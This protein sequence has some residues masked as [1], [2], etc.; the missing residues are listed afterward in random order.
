MADKAHRLTDKKL[1]EMEKRLSS[2]YSGSA[3]IIEK[4]AADYFRQ[5]ERMDE[6]KR[7][8]VEKGTLTDDEYKRWRKNKLLYAERF[9]TLQNQIATEMLNVNKTA[10]AYVN[11][12][13]PEVYAI[14]YNAIGETVDGVGGYSFTMVDSN[15]VK[16]LATR[17]SRLLP[18]KYIDQRKDKKW[19]MRN[20]H[21]SVLQSIL[22]GESIPDMAKRL[23]H[24][25]EMNKEQ[26]IRMARTLTT[27]AENK[28]RQDSCE[29]AVSDGIILEK[30]WIRT[31]DARTREEH[32]E[33]GRRY[34]ESRSIAIDKPFYVGGQYLMH[35]GDTSMGA[36]GSNIYNCRCTMGTVVKGIDFGE[37]NVEWLEP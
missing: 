33:A 28:G 1:A 14:N 27:A 22:T 30:F 10:I 2:I 9:K 29:Q 32:I 35:P 7:K 13:L 16:E 17:N 5:F 12:Q 21:R 25:E 36:S 24:V 4:K 11:G 26:S 20:V 18:Y 3:D 34:S 15:T 19:N 31:H 23:R 6:K 8:Q 37:G